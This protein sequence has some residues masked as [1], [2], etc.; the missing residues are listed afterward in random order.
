M[1]GS[2]LI[3]YAFRRGDLTIHPRCKNLIH[4][5]QHFKGSEEDLKHNLDAARYAMSSILSDKKGYFRL[6]FDSTGEIT[7]YG[8]R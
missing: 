4:S 8:R 7:N 6:R 1:Y 5:F 2:R 3:N